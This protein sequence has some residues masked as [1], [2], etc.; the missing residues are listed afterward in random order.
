M[1]TMIQIAL[2]GAALAVID[3]H[4]ATEGG[5]SSREDALVGIVA[6]WVRDY[7]AKQQQADEGLRPDQL[8]AS[9]DS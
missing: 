4:I 3:Q 7:A 9:N 8:N 5:A 6:A 1:P 2:D